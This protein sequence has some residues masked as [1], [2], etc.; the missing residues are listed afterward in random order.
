MRRF[1]EW[2]VYGFLRWFESF[3]SVWQTIV[4]CIGGTIFCLAFPGLISLT[5][6]VVLLSLYATF[7]QNGLA[8]ENK[9][10]SDGLAHNADLL[11]DLAQTMSVIL[12]ELRQQLIDDKE[13]SVDRT[14][15]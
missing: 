11:L 13:T 2:A 3:D 12:E 1:L 15:R 9:L 4:I 7:T 10:N 14:T 8:H 5:F 6:F